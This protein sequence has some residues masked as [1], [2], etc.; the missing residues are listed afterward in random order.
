MSTAD[1]FENFD[2]IPHVFTAN[3]NSHENFNATLKNKG[4]SPSKVALEYFKDENHWTVA[5][6]SLYHGMQFIYKD[7]KMK[8]IRTSSVEDI[9]SYYETNYN[10]GFLPTERAVNIVGYN[11]IKSDAK[12]ALKYFQLNVKNYPTSSNAFDSLG[13]AYMLSGNKK[14]A[15]KSYKKSFELDPNNGNALKMMQQLKS[16]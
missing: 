15:F 1:K 16:K 6:M 10:G 14:K 9:V 5:L 2:R 4:F 7:L 13:E 11:Y 8:N 3:I 12:K